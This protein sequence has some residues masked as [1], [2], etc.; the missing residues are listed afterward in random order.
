MTVPTSGGMGRDWF[1]RLSPEGRVEFGFLNGTACVLESSVKLVPSRWYHVELSVMGKVAAIK[2]D[3]TVVA[4]AAIPP[5]DWNLSRSIRLSG[6][7]W[8]PP[9]QKGYF[10]NHGFFC[11]ELR[12]IS[13]NEA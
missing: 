12:D 9:D 11:G 10:G 13:L 2:I 3:G 7:P 1:A 5:R 4:T 6:Y 8:E